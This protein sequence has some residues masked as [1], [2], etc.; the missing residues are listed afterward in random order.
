MKRP[1]LL[2]TGFVT[3]LSLIMLTGTVLASPTLRSGS[4][5]HDVLLLQKKLKNVGYTIHSV[6]GV[7]G[8]ET[9]RAVA[10]F[11][12][13]QKI[14]ITGTA[15]PINLVGIPP[16]PLTVP[17]TCNTSLPKTESRFPALQTNSINSG[18]G[19]P[20]VGSWFP[21]TWFSLRPMNPELHTAEFI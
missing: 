1:R 5:G 15:F 21:E 19:P 9:E 2:R 20:A 11:Q 17:D 18:G 6:D 13:D 12:R 8:D 3:C 10:E 16:K 4:T 14:R 7:Y